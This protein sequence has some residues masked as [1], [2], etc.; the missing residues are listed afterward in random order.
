[1]DKLQARWNALTSSI[2][3]GFA[4]GIWH[5]PLWVFPTAIEV[6]SRI[7]LWVYI[8]NTIMISI[9]MTWT[10][11]NTSRSM[12]SAIVMHTVLNISGTI[13]PFTWTDYGV[14]FNLLLQV[15]VVTIIV[16]IYGIESLMKHYS[17]T[18]Q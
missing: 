2:I 9:I 12:L 1:M 7:P 8:L 13:F 11:N 4:W 18:E 14:Y 6:Y 17:Q 16:A 5:L 3:I 15:V 10:Y